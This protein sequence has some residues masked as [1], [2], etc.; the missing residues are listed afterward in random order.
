MT[1]LEIL[2]ELK[3]AYDYIY[4]IEENAEIE[5]IGKFAK[6][7]ILKIE[8]KLETVYWEVYKKILKENKELLNYKENIK[9]GDSVYIDYTVID[10]GAKYDI[11][12]K[13][14]DNEEKWWENYNYLLK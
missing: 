12:Y 14:M 13:D 8:D 3:K 9:I 6:E 5:Q 2:A 7:E 10:N 1:E 11:T 4:D